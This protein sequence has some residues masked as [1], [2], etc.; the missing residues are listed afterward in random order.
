MGWNLLGNGWNVSLPVASFLGDATR[1]TTVWKWEAPKNGWQFYTPT[2]TAQDLQNYTAGK[3]YGMLSAVGAGE[4]YWVNVAQVFNLILPDSTP[5][6][7]SDFMAGKPHALNQGW[8]LV[9]IGN[10]IT[11]KNFH[12]VLSVAPPQTGT[13]IINFTTLW[14]WDN[15]QTKWYFYSFQLDAKGGTVLTDYIVGKGYIDFTAANKLLDAGSGFW[16]NKP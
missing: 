7:G 10:A 2:M 5:L 15:P 9:A 11:P 14:A 6:G 8:N 12:S 3:G 1:V 13:S 4:G 16:V